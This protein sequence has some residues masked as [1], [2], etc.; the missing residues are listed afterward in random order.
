MSLSF[1]FIPKYNYYNKLINKH[2]FE[3]PILYKF[4][5]D[6]TDNETIF[7][8]KKIICEKYKKILT[9]LYEEYIELNDMCSGEINETNDIENIEKE[10]NNIKLR[11]RKIKKEYFLHCK[12]L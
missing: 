4:S 6:I 9:E 11:I 8:K 2:N 5:K 12:N 7:D 3:I 10:I 1:S